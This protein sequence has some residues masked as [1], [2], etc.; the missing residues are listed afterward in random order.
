MKPLSREE[1][2]KLKLLPIYK[3]QVVSGSMEPVIRTGEEILI[4]VGNVDLKPFDI[5]VFYFDE[6]LICHF[7]WRKN[8][9]AHPILYQTRNMQ[10][11]ADLPITE[12]FI[13]GKVISHRIS[14][15]R[16]LKLLF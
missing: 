4:D 12:E 9:I 13:L 1:F 11:S 3:S 10:G 16:R 2:E 14:L 5:I 8:R 7:L 6:K 15:W